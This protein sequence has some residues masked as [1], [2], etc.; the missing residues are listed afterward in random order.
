MTFNKRQL[1]KILDLINELRD[2]GLGNFELYFNDA[3][4]YGLCGNI[5]GKKYDILEKLVEDYSV[6]FKGDFE[7]VIYTCFIDF[8][9][10]DL[11][12]LIDFE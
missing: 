7:L 5:K 6:T 12:V 8:D 1:V 2:Y 11:E 9:N 10:D 4:E 3:D